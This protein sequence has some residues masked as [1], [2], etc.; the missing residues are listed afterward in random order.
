MI[1]KKVDLDNNDGLCIYVDET[2]GRLACMQ[3]NNVFDV[4]DKF[5]SSI[6]PARVLEIGTA[7]A[8]L[9]CYVKSLLNKYSPTSEILSYDIHER[10]WFDELRKQ[11]VNIVIEN[12]FY[13]NYTR[14]SNN[15]I[16]YIQS[17]GITV[18][19]CDGEYKHHEFNLLSKFIKKGDFI[20]AHDYS[21]DLDFF[22]KN[23]NKKL[24][25][26]CEIVESDITNSV[27]EHNLIDYKNDLFNKAVWTCKVKQ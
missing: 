12:I 18:V 9:T 26:W 27:K 17:P 8:G 7:M 2:F 16:K 21:I 23:I 25:N 19:L 13:D 20:L 11:D 1:D 15:V 6:K 14:T 3:N 10:P 4:F 24:W 5:I 22:N